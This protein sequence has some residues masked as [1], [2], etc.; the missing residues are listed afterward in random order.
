M[1]NT[2]KMKFDNNPTCEFAEDST[3]QTC[4]NCLVRP[5]SLFNDLS[6][7]ELQLLNR[8]RSVTYYKAG[9]LIFKQGAR[10]MGLIC[11]AKGKVKITMDN[12]NGDAQIIALKKPVDFLGFS[13]LLGE[14]VYFT[15]AI[16]LEDSIVCATPKSCLTDI[17]KS[18]LQLAN[19]I[20]KHLSHELAMANQRMANLTQKHM[21]A[22]LADTLLYVY[23]TYGVA[24]NKVLNV[25]LKRS[26][27]ASL[28][29]M[30]TA[31]A[32]RTLSEFAKSDLIAVNGRKIQ[33]RNLGQ[34]QNISLTG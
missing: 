21:R 18:N 24:E 29:N 22:R 10:P 28:S 4:M 31:N 7:D 27:L 13:D 11:L 2:P 34:L 32:I 20:I 5:L 9:E 19:K 30:S 25:R 26:D 14:E 1:L 12:V 16:A 17:I 33:I 23:D 3:G 6:G 8:D 15:S